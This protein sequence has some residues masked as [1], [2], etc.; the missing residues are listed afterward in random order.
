[1]FRGVK[2]APKLE[3]RWFKLL[4][5]QSGV[6]LYSCVVKFNSFFGI[7]F[8]FNSARSFKIAPFLGVI[9]EELVQLPLGSNCGVILTL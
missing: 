3:L 4:Y 9:L 6:K 2:L 5:L 7:K 8:Q 1:M